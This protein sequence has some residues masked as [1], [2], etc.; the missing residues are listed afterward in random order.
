[1]RLPS[2]FS[3][4]KPKRL[5][6]LHTMKTRKETDDE[7]IARLR[8]EHVEN[9]RTMRLIREFRNMRDGASSTWNFPLAWKK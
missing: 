6:Y 8:R 1:M 5:G 4:D 2:P 9:S 7:K 3:L